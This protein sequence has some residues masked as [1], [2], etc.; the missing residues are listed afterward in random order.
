MSFCQ[1][2]APGS[3]T[4][5]TWL[6]AKCLPVRRASLCSQEVCPGIEPGLPLYQSGVPPKTPTDHVCF[7]LP[8]SPLILASSA[9]S[10]ASTA[11]IEPALSW[12]S[13]R[14]LRRWTTGL[15][16]SSVTRVGVEPTKSPRPQ[17]S[18]LRTRGS[19][20][21][22]SADRNY[23]ASKSVLWESNPPFQV[24]SLEP[25]PLG[26]GHLFCSLSAAGR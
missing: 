16:F 15:C 13:P 21:R 9:G 3:R 18:N 7:L 23:P 4:P 14:R 24:G 2:G 1:S 25:L 11:G 20:P 10:V 17:E 8:P 19:K 26:Q 12:L 5:I 22:I 6:Q